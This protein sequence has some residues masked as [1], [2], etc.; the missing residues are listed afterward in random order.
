MQA[1]WLSVVSH[2]PIT[3]HLTTIA[4]GVAHNTLSLLEAP[5]GSGKT[6]VLP[7]MLAEQ[8]WLEGKKVLVLQPRR[9][10]ATGVATRMAE[11][12]NEPVGETVGYQIRL[13]RKVSRKTRIEIIT[14]GLLTRRILSE[15]ELSDVGLIV[16][17]EFHERSIHAD[18]GLALAREVASVL[19]NDLRILVMSATL[20]PLRNHSLFSDSWSHSFTTEPH[21]LT[22]AYRHPEPRQRVW[23]Y[24]AQA[25]KNALMQHQGDLLSF[26][27]GAF[28]I[29][30]C[31]DLLEQAR[32]DAEIYPLFGDLPYHEQR[33]ALLPSVSGR[34]KVVLATPIAETSL[35]IDGVRIVVDSGLHKVAQVDGHGSTTL[36][37]ERISQDSADQR[38]GRAARTAPGVCI[39]LWSEQEHQTLRAAREPEISRSDLTQTALELA[40]WGVHDLNAFPWIS[41]PPSAALTEALSTLQNLGAITPD[42]GITERGRA[43]TELGTHPRLGALCLMA[44]TLGLIPVAAALISVLEERPD[45]RT[46]TSS[47]DIQPLVEALVTHSYRGS[48]RLNDLAQRWRRRLEQ[49]SKGSQR[50][51]SLSTEV[52][53]G[54]LLATAFPERIAQRR[55]PDST[56]YLL[57]NGKGVTLRNGDPLVKHEYIVVAATQDRNDDGLVSVAAALD[58]SL[59]SGHLAH[60]VDK[61]SHTTFNEHRGVLER[62][63]RESIGSIILR[64]GNLEPIPVSERAVALIDYVRSD[65]GFARLVFPETFAQLQ[66][67]VAWAQTIAPSIALPDLSPS[68][69]QSSLHE[70]LEPVLPSDGRLSSITESV[71]DAALAILL[72]WNTRRELEQIAPDSLLLPNGKQR[73][74]RYDASEGPILEAM[75]QELFGLA[76]TPRIGRASIPATVHLLSPARRPMQVTKDLAS[77]WK[78]GYP[79]V[80][81]ELRG[82]Y[83]KHRWPEDPLK[84][85]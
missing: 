48:S 47:A 62:R 80:R 61:H 51:E 12:L 55:E 2:L 5:P 7:L 26:L 8:P 18:V 31:R 65:D 9:L 30:R 42:G 17:D 39:R 40:A 10:A 74:I 28:E 84:P 60:L 70:W 50:Q 13:D 79:L 36:R 32:I 64:E 53:C 24:T 38:A 75:I 59:L 83:P 77:F 44:D 67:R 14:E 1:R 20:G 54:L 56:K 57:A 6:T 16:F 35:T 82:R 37:T 43:L 41:A 15:P 71:L 69:L 19:R 63:A 46:T 66:S 68:A 3:A 27:P 23:E 52:A 21:P 85:G 11:L 49:R 78:N 45:T 33:L 4:E 34:R 73:R 58:P 72:P 22:I 76:E 81:K 29:Q 25:I